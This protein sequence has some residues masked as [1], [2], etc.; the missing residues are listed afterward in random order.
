[1]TL[2]DSE[3]DAL[4]ELA[5]ARSEPEATTAARLLRAG[6]IDGGASLA[7]AVRRRTAPQPDNRAGHTAS[8]AIWLPPNRR[9]AAIEQL[10]ARYP[11]TLRHLRPEAL[12]LLEV[13][14]PVSAL[15]LM[16]EQIDTGRY[17]DPRIELAF[18]HELRVFAR[19]LQEQRLDRSQ[20]PGS[21]VGVWG[22]CR[23]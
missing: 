14:E 21:G 10:R 8:A 17:D 9:I 23:R 18:S 3:L 12:D 22:S 11:H 15:S 20:V 2:R 4:A 19:W 13:A 6:L 1:V 7:A 5:A 16:R